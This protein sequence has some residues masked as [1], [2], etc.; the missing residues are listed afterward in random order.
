MIQQ[1]EANEELVQTLGTVKDA[2]KRLL[3]QIRTQNDEITRL[4]QNRIADEERMDVLVKRHKSDHE[5]ATRQSQSHFNAL[6]QQQDER[7]NK[8]LRELTDKLRHVKAQLDILRQDMEHLKGEHRIDIRKFADTVQQ[9][10]KDVEL[11]TVSA[12]SSH[13]KRQL[14]RKKVVEGSIQGLSLELA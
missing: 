5:T 9:K 8:T 6:Q 1:A 10:M 12:L 4:T 7:Y 2:N 13:T 3:E 11:E 14:E